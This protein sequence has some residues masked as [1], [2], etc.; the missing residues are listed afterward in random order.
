MPPRVAEQPQ[1]ELTL[2]PGAAARGRSLTAAQRKRLLL[3]ACTLD[4]M[5]L[6]RIY[7]PPPPNPF[8]RAMQALSW[9]R[10]GIEAVTPFLPRRLRLLALGW[11]V[12]RVARAARG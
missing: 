7:R 12:W 10:A 6:L 9:A 5:Q 4:R 3:I 1:R 11:R 2:P 8:A